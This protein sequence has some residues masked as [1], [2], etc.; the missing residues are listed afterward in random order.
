M[1]AKVTELSEKLRHLKKSS[2][3]SELKM[4][5]LV[6]SHDKKASANTHLTH[7]LDM[8]KRDKMY[9]EEEC[10]KCKE[11]LDDALAQGRQLQFQLEVM[12]KH[13]L[14][15]FISIYIKG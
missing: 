14:F 13:E 5:A 10:K 1:E 7:D 6:E 2:E 9:L 12:L 15:F 8:T 4:S 11:K 3:E